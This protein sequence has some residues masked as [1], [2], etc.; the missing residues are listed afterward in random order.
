M[1]MM[2]LMMVLMMMM[3]MM[4]MMMVAMLTLT[5]FGRMSYTHSL[6]FFPHRM[7]A[8]GAGAWVALRISGG[9]C[10]HTPTL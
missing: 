6:M 5:K 4:M 8:P 2:V 7:F 9:L 1:T 10:F 3:V